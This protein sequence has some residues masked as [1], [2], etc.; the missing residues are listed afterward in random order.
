MRHNVSHKTR[1]TPKGQAMVSPRRVSRVCAR[2][3]YRV[4]AYIVILGAC[5]AS[6][7]WLLTPNSEGLTGVE[8]ATENTVGA[9]D[10]GTSAAPHSPAKPEQGEDS[11][12]TLSVTPATLQ[13]EE[14]ACAQ[15][16]LETYST[17]SRVLNVVGH[18]HNN[19]GNR[20]AALVH[21]QR[22]IALDPN[23]A[24]AYDAMA[25]VAFLKEDNQ[26]AIRLWQ[27]TLDVAPRMPG[28][29]YQLAT[30][31]MGVGRLDEAAAAFGREIEIN[32]HVSSTHAMLGEVT[33]LLGHYDSALISFK[34][35]VQIDPN[36]TKACY[37]LATVYRA[38]KD[39]E[40][41]E[42][43]MVRFR[44]LKDIDIQGDHDRRSGYDDMDDLRSLAARTFTEVASIYAQHG[45]YQSAEP[46]WLRASAL[47]TAQ[48]SCRQNLGQLY[49][50]TNRIDKAIEMC[51]QLTK[52]DPGNP[53]YLVNMG[54]FY[55][56]LEQYDAAIDAMEKA[57][58][59][60]SE[61]SANF[62]FLTKIYLQTSRDAD[63]A[64]AYA[65]RAVD[66]EPSAA[67]YF[68]LG[69]ALKGKDDQTGALAAFQRAAELD[70][71]KPQ[72]QSNYRNLRKQMPQEPE[73][74]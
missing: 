64:I 9:L 31:L 12:L 71:F 38:L 60:D 70:P 48:L 11:E 45:D 66:L 41:S 13:A 63:Q 43:W 8:P 33:R 54:V 7:Y 47:D 17:E 16:L 56:R 20:T 19:H 1:P 55:A 15:R 46:L 58:G 32:P 51:K 29:H 61:R 22:A 10:P 18:I 36:A 39:K 4:L 3:V 30:A 67:N 26:E 14:L 2:S 73:D 40:Q 21:W 28:T 68:M 35:A 72:Y 57:N 25:K 27:K 49:H 24:V 34:T 6:G 69:T 50:Y 74:K 37:G 5:W 42:Q 59:L 65:R 53:E 44:Q 23:N 52:L 62:R